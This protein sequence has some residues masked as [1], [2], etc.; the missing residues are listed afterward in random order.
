MQENTLKYVEAN[1][2]KF[3][4]Q[5]AGKGDLLLCLH[6]Y[7]DTADTWD[8]H[9]PVL[10]EAGYH[11]VAPYMRGYWPTQIPEPDAYSNQDLGM[12]VI[13]LIEALGYSEAIVMGHDWGA[14]AA[15][16]AANLGA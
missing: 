16:T 5:D 4:Y 6:G 9:M 13:A 7:P 14:L 1:G 2:L 10:A 3:A 11:V 12:D 8:E 15:Y